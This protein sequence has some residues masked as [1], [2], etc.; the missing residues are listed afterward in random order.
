MDVIQIPD[1]CGPGFC[2]L[3]PSATYL[4]HSEGTGSVTLLD[5]RPRRVGRRD[6]V[7]RYLKHARPLAGALAFIVGLTL[8]APPAFASAPVIAPH[9]IA[10]AA[11]AKVEAMPAASLARAAQTAPAPAADAAGKPFLKTTRGAVALALLAGAFGYAVYS[12]SNG[13]VRSPA[14]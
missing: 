10:A 7:T 1:F 2:M 11:T 5:S 13:R 12:F 3:P 14:K 9:P 6:E 4:P 8:L